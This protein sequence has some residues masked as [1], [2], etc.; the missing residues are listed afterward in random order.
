MVV[1]LDELSTYT[2]GNSQEMLEDSLTL[3]IHLKDKCVVVFHC[4]PTDICNCRGE[5]KK[6]IF[7][8]VLTYVMFQSLVWSWGLVNSM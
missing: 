4:L 3:T 8:N 5:V 7:T 6:N 2:T 1:L